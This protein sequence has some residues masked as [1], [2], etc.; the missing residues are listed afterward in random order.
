MLDVNKKLLNRS[1]LFIFVHRCPPEIPRGF[2]HLGKVRIDTRGWFDWGESRKGAL[3]PFG[4]VQCCTI[5]VP[6]EGIEPSWV[7]RAGNSSHDRTHWSE[8]TGL[9]YG[10]SIGQE[11]GGREKVGQGLATLPDGTPGL[12]GRRRGQLAPD[13]LFCCEI[14]KR[15]GVPSSGRLSGPYRSPFARIRKAGSL[16]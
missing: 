11:L 14:H 9:S 3:W 1:S 6:G 16:I 13:A 10:P 15:L 4:L 2:R 5:R 12:P 8:V 7:P